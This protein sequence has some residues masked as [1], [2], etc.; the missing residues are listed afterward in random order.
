MIA[1]MTNVRWY[2]IIVLMCIFLIISDIEHFFMCLSAICMSSL[3]KYLF[4]SSVHLS[5]FF[6]FFFAVEIYELFVY[7][8]D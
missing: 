1:I 2:F 5:I 3:K 8:G 7:F 6:F 4:R